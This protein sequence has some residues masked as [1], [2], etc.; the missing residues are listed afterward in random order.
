[1]SEPSE[2]S[3]D[4]AESRNAWADSKIERVSNNVYR[5]PLPMP[6]DGLRAINVYALLDEEGVTLIDAGWA[7]PEAKD[8]LGRALA[9]FDCGFADIRE[10]VATHVHRDHYTM[11]IDIRRTFGSR[12]LL[13]EGE[14]A[15]LLYMEELIAGTAQ[16]G[17]LARLHRGGASNLISQVTPDH[18]PRRSDWEFPDHWLKDGAIL[19]VAG[20]SLRV[21]ATPGHT[22]GHLVFH[23]ADDGLLF[24]GDHVLPHITPSIGFQ[25]APYSQPLADYLDSLQLMLTLPDPRLL[26]AHGPAG[27]S[28]HARVHELLDHHELRL[29][30]ALDAV[31]TTVTAH[32]VAKVVP[33]TRHKRE[34]TDLAPFDQVLA[35]NETGAHLDVLSMRGYLTD[36][37]REDG[38]VVYRRR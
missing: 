22:S 15:N 12:V 21:I 6:G 10:F 8:A 18:T 37:L 38:S 26:P 11:A 13:G 16:P 36:E 14:R 25:P 19:E 7:L 34:F 3:I 5:I 27:G 20:R 24:S 9:E 32:Q 4:T 35:V 2:R 23:D 31:D 30:E 1:M 28:T 29:A 33:W 17:Y